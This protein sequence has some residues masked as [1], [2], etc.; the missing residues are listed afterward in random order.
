MLAALLVRSRR[1]RDTSAAVCL[2]S[3]AL[4]A[5]SMALLRRSS[6]LTGASDAPLISRSARTTDKTQRGGCPAPFNGTTWAGPGSLQACSGCADK[7]EHAEIEY[8]I[9]VHETLTFRFHAECY[10]A[11]LSFGR[12]S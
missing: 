12:T 6:P 2:K 7:V 11:W 3:Q 4:I 8:E 10:R 5:A 1:N 9:E